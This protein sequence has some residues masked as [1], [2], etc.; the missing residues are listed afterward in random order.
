M[1]FTAIWRDYALAWL[2]GFS[3]AFFLDVVILEIAVELFICM[4]YSCRKA[5]PFA[6]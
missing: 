3:I 1:T 6:L 4:F 5:S 2:L